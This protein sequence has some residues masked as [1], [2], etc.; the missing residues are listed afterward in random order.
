MFLCKVL[1]IDYWWW[2][3]IIVCF[4]VY[5]VCIF[6]SV[7]GDFTDYQIKSS[8]EKKFSYFNLNNF[9]AKSNIFLSYNVNN[10]E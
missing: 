6:L 5:Y 10:V 4:F 8:L 9:A 1:I 3:Y 2:V 7:S